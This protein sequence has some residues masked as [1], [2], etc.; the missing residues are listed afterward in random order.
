[1]HASKLYVAALFLI[2]CLLS[3]AQ[4]KVDRRT[5]LNGNWHLSGMWGAPTETPHLILSLGVSGNEVFG[6][7]DLDVHCHTNA[8]EKRSEGMGTQFHVEGRIEPDGTFFL[9]PWAGEFGDPELIRIRGRIPKRSAAQWPGRVEFDFSR[10][11]R[12]CNPGALTEDFVATRLPLL[13]GEYSGTVHLNYGSQ[14]KISLQITQGELVTFKTKLGRVAGQIPLNATMTLTA[15]S[16]F[17]LDP[18]IFS[19]EKLTADTSGLAKSRLEGDQ[20]ILVFPTKDGYGLEVYGSYTDASEKTLR[21]H[22]LRMHN[23]I[24]YATLTKQ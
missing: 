16:T 22:L 4:E 21:V 2:S 10:L 17:L 7:A 18:S 23:F 1:M 19:A 15:S 20:F 14:G 3:H 11:R 5:V 9:K 24:G 13:S 12:P 8:N 6:G